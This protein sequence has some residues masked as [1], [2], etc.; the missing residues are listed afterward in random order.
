MKQKL[1]VISDLWGLKKGAYLN[2]YINIL[3]PFFEVNVIDSLKLANIDQRVFTKES[4]HRQFIEGGIDR[5]S[6]RLLDCLDEPCSVLAFSVGGV[7]AWKAAL[8]SHK[9]KH[10]ICISSTRLRYEK[11][12]PN[13]LI[14]LVYGSEEPYAP[15]KEWYLKQLIDPVL[16]P[17]EKH[18]FYRT[19]GDV[20]FFTTQLF[21]QV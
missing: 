11:Q 20:S 17:N 8:Q 13:C 21:D 15:N 6:K 5:A 14:S 12:K 19:I 1:I 3:E 10:L 9:I 2:R 4:I 18:D 7:I 16:I